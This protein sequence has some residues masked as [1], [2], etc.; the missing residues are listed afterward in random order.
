MFY[1]LSPGNRAPTTY[2]SIFKDEKCFLTLIISRRNSDN[3]SC[4]LEDGG[5]TT[6]I[7]A[8]LRWQPVSLRI[9]FK[10]LWITSRLRR[11]QATQWIVS[12][13]QQDDLSFLISFPWL[14]ESGFFSLAQDKQNLC[15]PLSCLLNVILI[16]RTVSY[17]VEFNCFP[18]LYLILSLF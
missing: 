11:V 14:V 8:C 7:L 2:F 17:V 16:E 3:S 13:L 12:F 10:V 9:T 5:H 4:I 1:D 18:H 6:A 15:R